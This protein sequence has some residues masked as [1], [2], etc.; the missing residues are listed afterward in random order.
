MT[1]KK[2]QE[3]AAQHIASNY[4]PSGTCSGLAIKQSAIVAEL[5]ER[6]RLVAT[7]DC[8]NKLFSK[9]DCKR[10]QEVFIPALQE[11]SRQIAAAQ[12]AGNCG[13]TKDGSTTMSLPTKLGQDIAT[14]AIEA[15]NVAAEQ[16][17]SKTMRNYL[18]IG[19]VAVA[20][21]VAILIIKR[22]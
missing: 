14:A 11:A 13:N 19:G 6:T 1:K 21:I 18:I 4:A 9:N 5:G 2:L 10:E 20:A 7:G 17:E 12:K 22:K 16:E 3:L 8:K 15:T